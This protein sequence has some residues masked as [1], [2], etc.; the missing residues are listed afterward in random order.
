MTA[1]YKLDEDGDVTLK[2]TATSVVTYD[3]LE[4]QYGTL[5][6]Q[7]NAKDRAIV[8]VAEQIVSDVSLYYAQLGAPPSKD[9]AHA[10]KATPEKSWSLRAAPVEE[11]A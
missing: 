9:P 1:P 3:K 10:P 2:G 4:A 7:R 8:E 11:S 5:A 6:A